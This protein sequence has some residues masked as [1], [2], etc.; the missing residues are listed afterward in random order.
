MYSP[1]VNSVP[2]Y[3][4]HE[5]V[6]VVLVHVLRGALFLR[7]MEEEGEGEVTVKISLRR[8]VQMVRVFFF[9]LFLYWGSKKDGNIFFVD[10]SPYT[11]N[12]LIAF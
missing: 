9:L 10:P 2:W 3:T 8:V 1:L 4:V 12:L 7:G 6:V 11:I 5:R